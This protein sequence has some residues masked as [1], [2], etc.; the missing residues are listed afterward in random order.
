LQADL[1]QRFQTKRGYPGMEHTVDWLSLDLSASYFPAETRDNFG[2]P[3][4]FIEYD[5]AWYVGDQT[6]ITSGGWFDPFDPGTRYYNIGAFLNRPDRTSYYLGYRQTDP[7][8]SKAVNGSVSYFFS[9]K[10]SVVAS[11]SYDFGTSI[12]QSSS[13][14]FARTGTDLT[15]SVGVTYN[16]ILKNF[17]VTF[18]LVPNL[19]AA[20]SGGGLLSGLTGN[21]A[22]SGQRR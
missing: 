3:I 10:Y 14:A 21:S 7:L 11:T 18:E 20:R 19:L 2:K 9:Q 17:G 8:G 15:V 1:R 12:T 16:S 6:A 5:A 4:S 13:L 22:S